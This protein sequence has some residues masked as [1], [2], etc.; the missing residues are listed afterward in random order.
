MVQ[1]S[2][3]SLKASFENGDIRVYERRNYPCI[4]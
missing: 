3:D 2:K 4:R 1:K